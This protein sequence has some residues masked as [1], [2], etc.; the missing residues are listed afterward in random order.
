MSL[1]EFFKEWGPTIMEVAPFAILAMLS[2]KFATK[3]EVR[4]ARAIADD[5]T[6]R[7]DVIDE[8]MKH[9]PT[10]ADV[11][12]LRD[13]VAGLSGDVKK[14]GAEVEKVDEKTDRQTTTLDRIELHLLNQVSRAA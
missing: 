6:G 3:G 7:L 1:G 13:A 11:Q 2:Q 4:E 8:R 12:Q 10:S 14:L 5:N 9:M